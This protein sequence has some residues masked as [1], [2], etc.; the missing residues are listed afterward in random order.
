LKNTVQKGFLKKYRRS[1]GSETV[2]LP[3]EKG[4]LRLEYGL[5]DNPGWLS[6]VSYVLTNKKNAPALGK[7]LELVLDEEGQNI[8]TF[9][10]EMG[11]SGTQWSNGHVIW[12]HTYDDDSPPSPGRK[13]SLDDWVDE[14][15][16]IMISE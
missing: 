2:F 14:C 6:L 16:N 3:L 10:A 13:I 11:V 5:Y 4:Y 1:K 15:I 8:V 12:G 7:R 9:I